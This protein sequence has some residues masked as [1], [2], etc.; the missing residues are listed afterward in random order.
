R[1][2]MG[3]AEPSAWPALRRLWTMTSAAHTGLIV[4][5][6]DSDLASTLRALC[7]SIA[8]FTR[9][10]VAAVPHNQ[11]RAFANEPDIRELT[12][13][14]TS[15][16]V[17]QDP[18]SLPITR[19]LA[20]TLCNLVTANE[21]LM[22]QLWDCYLSLP[23]EQLVLTRLLAVQ[24]AVTTMSTFV[25]VLNCLHGSPLRINRLNNSPNGPR[26]CI[27]LLDRMASLFDAE[28]TSDTTRAFDIG[29]CI[30][31]Q[32]VEA[33]TAPAAYARV[34]I[35][36]EVVTPHQTTFLKL[37]DA[38]L[39]PSQE[40]PLAIDSG[41]MRDLSGFLSREFLTLSTYCQ[42]AIRRAP[43]EEEPRPGDPAALQELDL[44]LPKVCEA[45]VLVTQ[46]LTSLCLISEE[47]ANAS[48]T[49]R[50]TSDKAPAVIRAETL[51]SLDL[52]LPRITLGKAH[53][54][55]TAGHAR[56][57][58]PKGFSYLKRDL[59]RLLGILSS[60][61]R[62]VQDRVRVCGGIQVVMNL[63]VIDERN[64]Y[65]REHA[66]LALRNLLHRNK[67]N[68]MLVNEIQPIAEWDDDGMLQ[69][70]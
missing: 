36:D 67:E 11:E 40:R 10:L 52:F 59:V 42:H 12:R 21:S 45:L 33:G 50:T 17:L 38:Y 2:D 7:I 48:P 37:L 64:P 70:R 27:S 46:C 1:I 68:Q 49:Q 47:S 43:A 51:R 54:Q 58:D 5:E 22:Q 61:R 20:Q 66:I 29:Y 15:Y 14:Y 25:L 8:R 41:E 62:S 6:D 23:E 32:I 13:Y 55:D 60:E 57:S 65:L 63:C 30:F 9:N 19:M 28:E 34:A 53:A 31:C 24:D 18:K 26:L 56:P 3:R 69:R 35:D 4:D 44:L 16:V 39:Q